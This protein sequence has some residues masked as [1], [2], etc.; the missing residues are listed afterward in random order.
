MMD[1]I[2]FEENE[3]SIE[4]ATKEKIRKALEFLDEYGKKVYIYEYSGAF[5]R[6]F[7]IK[8]TF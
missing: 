5:Y 7:T 1:A 6:I 4:E 3:G 8:P 2:I